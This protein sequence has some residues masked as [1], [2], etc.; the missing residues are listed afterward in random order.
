MDMN[1]PKTYQEVWAI[2]EDARRSFKE[3]LDKEEIDPRLSRLYER[4]ETLII[5]TDRLW[6]L[7]VIPIQIAQ[8][9]QHIYHILEV[10]AEYYGMIVQ[11]LQSRSK[12]AELVHA[13]HVAIYLCKTRHPK[14]SWTYL[15]KLLKRDH[16]SMIYAYNS[17]E[18]W[19]DIDQD[20]TR[21]VHHLLTQIS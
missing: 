9:H 17:I 3:A 20:L 10:T 13:R 8:S 2:L 19:I 18:A 14:V 12:K 1:P 5:E 7:S 21:E 16:S 15:A 6:K 4:F 11:Q